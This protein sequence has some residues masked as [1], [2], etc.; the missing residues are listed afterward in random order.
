ME[1]N[2]SYFVIK[3]DGLKYFPEIHSELTSSFQGIK[4]YKVKDYSTLIKKL[5]FRHYENKGQKFIE[6]FE[7]YLDASNSLYGNE[8]ILA[9]VQNETDSNV[10]EFRQRVFDTKMRIRKKFINPD[11]GIVTNDTNKRKSN[12]IKVVGEDGSEIKQPIFNDEGNYRIVFLN[13]IH[14]PDPN[15]QSTMEELKIIYD[16]GVLSKENL[17]GREG[18]KSLLNHRTVRRRANRRKHKTNRFKN[19][20]N[21]TTIFKT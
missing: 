7:K 14:S 2:Y 13:V 3:P 10:E 21:K 18:L 12:Y 16:S 9:L 19:R 15:M 11:L 4:Y 17:I 6:S 20:K 8:T 1:N 5:Y